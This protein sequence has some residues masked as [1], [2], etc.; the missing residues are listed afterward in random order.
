MP[1]QYAFEANTNLIYLWHMD[2]II[3]LVLYITENLIYTQ[4]CTLGYYF[5]I[6]RDYP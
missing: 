2:L 3:I 4:L 1:E 5:Y 6:I